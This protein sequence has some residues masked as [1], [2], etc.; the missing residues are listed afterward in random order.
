MHSPGPRPGF[1]VSGRGF[2]TKQTSFCASLRAFSSHHFVSR[3]INEKFL[4]FDVV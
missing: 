3:E 1:L 2:P 4:F